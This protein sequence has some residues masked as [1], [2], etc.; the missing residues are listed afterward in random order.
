MKKE[1]PTDHTECYSAEWLRYEARETQKD[2]FFSEF[3]V[4]SVGSKNIKEEETNRR[5]LK[6]RESEMKQ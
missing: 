3:S 6:Y 2:N 4:Y 5:L 1:G